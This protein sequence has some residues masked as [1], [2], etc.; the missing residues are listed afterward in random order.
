MNQP[1]HEI[2]ADFNATTI[3]VYQAFSVEIAA[4]A[5]KAQT[6]VEP[7]SFT[8]MTWIKPSFLWLMERSR[9]GQSKGQDCILAIRITREGFERALRL[10]VLTSPDKKIHQSTEQWELEMKSAPVMVQ[11]D[12]ER[13]LHGQKLMHRSLQVGVGRSQ[14]TDYTQRWIT[15]IRDLTALTQKLRE[16]RR[17]GDYK[18]AE[19]LL[20][21]QRP[22]PTPLDIKRRLGISA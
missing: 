7:F 15:E 11:W 22:Y 3:V 6:F 8:R 10:S 13:S 18:L 19:R 16:L 1:M 14:L 21:V 20:P 12:P 9:W 17:T 5:L 2:R 4:P